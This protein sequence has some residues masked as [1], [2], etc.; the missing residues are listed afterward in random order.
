MACLCVSD[1]TEVVLADHEAEVYDENGPEQGDF[2][3]FKSVSVEYE[4]VE[5]E[6][7]GDKVGYEVYGA[8]G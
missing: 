5:Y 8:F 3:K 7:V 4:G 1:I 6:V 2:E